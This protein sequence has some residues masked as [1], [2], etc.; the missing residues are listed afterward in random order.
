MIATIASHAVWGVYLTRAHRE[1]GFRAELPVAGIKS[2]GQGLIVLSR[3]E[4]DRKVQASEREPKSPVPHRTAPSPA[5]QCS[6]LWLLV[7]ACRVT[8]REIIALACAFGLLLRAHLSD[9]PF[10]IVGAEG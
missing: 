9:E 4:A 6:G 10:V 1:H 8:F 5:A 3:R 7:L 2:C